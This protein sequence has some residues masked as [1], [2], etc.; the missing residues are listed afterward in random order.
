MFRIPD[1]M[2][3]ARLAAYAAEATRQQQQDSSR[4]LNSKV[5]YICNDLELILGE[6]NSRAFTALNQA[7]QHRL[8]GSRAALIQAM[9]QL[10]QTTTQE[11]LSAAAD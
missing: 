2:S 3:R 6:L 10:R 5:Q 1:A 4:D 8:A 9:Q 11:D 7:Q